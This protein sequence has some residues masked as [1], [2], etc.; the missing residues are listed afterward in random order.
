MRHVFVETNFLIALLRPFPQPDAVSL[1]ARHGHDATLHLPWCAFTEAARTLERIVR[2]DL[3]FVDGTG[4]FFGQLMAGTP[5]PP[6]EFEHQVRL[7]IDRG[8]S[9]RREALAEYVDALRDVQAKV[10]VLGPTQA[11]VD[12]TL[13]LFAIKALTPFDEMVLG[14]VLEGA[15]ELHARGERDL[16]FCNLNKHDFQPKP[17]NELAAAYSEAGLRYID[18]FDV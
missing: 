4:R 16:W 2:D 3:A 7:F 11:L 10:V 5:R 9:R 18:S 12:R 15:S 13:R 1:Y 14:A 6:P 17:G 8:R